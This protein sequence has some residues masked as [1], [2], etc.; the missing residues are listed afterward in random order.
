MIHVIDPSTDA[1]TNHVD[2]A[3]DVTA[4]VQSALSGSKSGTAD[5]VSTRIFCKDT[6]QLFD[7]CT[8][9]VA[10][11]HGVVYQASFRHQLDVATALRQRLVKVA[12]VMAL[13][14]R[15]G[16]AAEHAASALL[17][18]VVGYVPSDRGSM[19]IMVPEK[20]LHGGLENVRGL[21][22]HALQVGRGKT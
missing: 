1:S 12:D 16:A 4:P 10:D 19:M 13:Q 18:T 20:G 7:F 8:S 14:A 2:N 11:V 6:D 9:T 17:E 15:R 5:I 3:T 21:L 22:K